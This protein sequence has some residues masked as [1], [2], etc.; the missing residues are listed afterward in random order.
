MKDLKETTT[1]EREAENDKFIQTAELETGATRV[2]LTTTVIDL[3][4]VLRGQ[5]FEVIECIT[6]L[7]AVSRTSTDG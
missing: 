7:N 4:T 2:H 1:G 3:I 5:I 6:R